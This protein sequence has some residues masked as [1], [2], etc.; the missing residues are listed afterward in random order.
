MKYTTEIEINLPRERVIE[1]FDN[2][3]NLSKWQHELRSFEHLSGE[4]GQP[5]A[6]SKLIYKMGKREV[7][8]IE[9][10]TKRELPDHFD[11]TYEANGVYNMQKNRFIDTGKGTTLW[12]SESEFRFSGFMK[13]MAFFMKGAFKKQTQKFMQQFKEFAESE[14]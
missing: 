4:P 14:G 8:M 12:I 7:E 5:G 13:V 10:V 1:L 11:G 2:P 3:D 6:K 9:T